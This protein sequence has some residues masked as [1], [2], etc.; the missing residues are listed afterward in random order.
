M[1]ILQRLG[2]HIYTLDGHSGFLVNVNVVSSLIKCWSKNRKHDEYRIN[3]LAQYL[4][5]DGWV[6]PLIYIANVPGEGLVCYDG[7]HR[8]EAY[9]KVSPQLD[10]KQVIV[11][12]LHKSSDIYDAYNCINKSVPLAQIDLMMD[13]DSMKIREELDGFM[14]AF[15][16]RYQEYLSPS[17]RSNRP[18]FN[19]DN[20]KDQLYS[21][22][23]RHEFQVSM[24][25]LKELLEVL[26]KAYSNNTRAGSNQKT[27]KETVVAKCK[28][29][30]LWL[31]AWR[32]DLP[33]A[34][35]DWALQQSSIGDFIKL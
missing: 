6:P 7:N 26:N 18:N 12:I 22:L 27:L 11:D 1:D 19:R 2:T 33:E 24:D 34:D 30:K 3:E 20:V 32:R 35:L 4:L 16:E 31:F 10:K 23:V 17:T 15:S 9:K 5:Q 29:G 28:K 25:K 8:R 21:F 14:T 13:K